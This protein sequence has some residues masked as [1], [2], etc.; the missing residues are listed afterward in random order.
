M[1][2][3]DFMRY[4]L[5]RQHLAGNR[6]LEGKRG[7]LEA[8]AQLQGFEVAASAWERDVLP[9]RVANYD[10]RW[11]DELCLSGDVAWARLSLRKTQRYRRAAR[12]RRARRRSRWCCA[13][14]SAGCSKPSAARRNLSRR[15]P[16]RQAPR[17]TRCARTARCSSTTC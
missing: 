14:I 3:Q 2:A 11:L 17:T 5:E 16:A 4:L 7:V 1:S 6:R 13:A 12:R 9:Q 15:R 10:P 8:I